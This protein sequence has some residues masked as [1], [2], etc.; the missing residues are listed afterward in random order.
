M[1]FTVSNNK[2]T[3]FLNYSVFVMLIL[4]VKLTEPRDAQRA[5]KTL[6]L[7]VCKRVFLEEISI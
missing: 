4:Y 2:K 6:F 3:Y 1:C 5:G 7:G